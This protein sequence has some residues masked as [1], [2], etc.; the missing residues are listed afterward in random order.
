MWRNRFGY[1]L[2]VFAMAGLIIP[3]NGLNTGFAHHVSYDHEGYLE[4]KIVFLTSR[5]ECSQRNFDALFFYAKATDDILRLHKIPNVLV[6]D[7]LCVG[8]DKMTAVIENLVS[9]SDLAIIIP[10]YLMSVKQRH[11]AGN[12]GHYAYAYDVKSI[13][14]QAETLSIENANTAWTLSHEIAHFALHYY[15]YPKEIRTDGVHEIQRQYNN[16]KSEDIT[17]ALCVPLWTTIK[18]PSGKYYAVM[19][20]LYTEQYTAPESTK[21]TPKSSTVD[22]TK[23][24]LDSKDRKTK[25]L[26]DKLWNGY[27]HAQNGGLPRFQFEEFVS[28][29]AQGYVSMALKNSAF[30]YK[31]LERM[32]TEYYQTVTSSM[33]DAMK[34]R[35][36]DEMYDDLVRVQEEY[37][38][39]EKRINSANRV[40]AEYREKLAQQE[41]PKTTIP[42]PTT[43]SPEIYTD[44]E[45]GPSQL[46]TI[47]EQLRLYDEKQ[48]ILKNKIDQLKSKTG[49]GKTFRELT[50]LAESMEDMELLSE[51]TQLL[52]ER[53]HASQA[54]KD[55]VKENQRLDSLIRGAVSLEQEFQNKKQSTKISEELVRKV[56]VEKEIQSLR[57]SFVDAISDIEKGVEVSEK[58][59]TGLTFQKK[60]A[61]EKIN[62]AWDLLKEDKNRLNAFDNY[63]LKNIDQH[64]KSNYLDGVDRSVNSGMESARKAG[65]NLVKISELIEEAKQ[66]EKQK[67][68]FLWWCW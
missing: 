52:I 47:N 44:V 12:L 1:F 41:A 51:L 21:I 58:S 29:S 15:G 65:E 23:S 22:Q 11:T 32:Y 59:L 2:I 37:D 20:P 66:L 42:N 54:Y 31:E 38:W 19:K 9:T 18:T 6:G 10:D 30:A 8:K 50:D 62:T 24:L 39:A 13:V 25:D 33:S 36:L 4:W 7:L 60:E 17:L 53:G 46:D 57:N 14:V 56:Q 28:P 68:C 40:E 64:S 3:I 67:F 43:K 34:I 5:D 45:R 55:I 63:Y 27:Y 49:L 61:Q 35:F 48:Q 26:F 16:C